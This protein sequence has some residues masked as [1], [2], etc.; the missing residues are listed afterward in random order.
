[1][2]DPVAQFIGQAKAVRLSPA[3]RNQLLQGIQA[4]TETAAVRIGHD[5]R[6]QVRMEQPTVDTFVASAKSVELSAQ[7]RMSLR[8]ALIERM[9]RPRVHAW[10]SW[11]NVAKGMPAFAA[12]L[13]LIGTGASAS[14][15]AENSVPGDLLYPVK[16]HVNEV[17]LQRFAVSA[18]D[19]AR[20]QAKRAIRRLREAEALA[21]QHRLSEESTAQLQESFGMHAR[22]V[23]RSIALMAAS[24]D[25]TAASTVG[26]EF[27]ASLE[28][29]AVIM[30]RLA[31]QR[32]STDEHLEQLASQVRT[33]QRD[34]ER[35]RVKVEIALSA[36]PS[37]ERQA[38]ALETVD[39][40][41][42]WVEQSRQAVPAPEDVA[43]EQLALADTLLVQAKEKI[44]AGS[45]AD[46]FGLVR[47]GIRNAEEARLISELQLASPTTI[48]VAL[49][50][51]ADTAVFAPATDAKR[52]AKQSDTPAEEALSPESEQ[53]T[54]ARALPDTNA[55]RQRLLAVRQE[56][57]ASRDL[58]AQEAVHEADVKL[59]NAEATLTM[60]DDFV[61]QQNL[62]QAK[63]YAA[64]VVATLEYVEQFAVKK[65]GGG[66]PSA[67]TMA[68]AP[69]VPMD[70][71]PQAEQGDTGVPQA[72]Q[73]PIMSPSY[74]PARKLIEE[75]EK[76]LKQSEAVLDAETLRSAGE[77]LLK[78]RNALVDAQTAFDVGDDAKAQEL[79]TRVEELTKKTNKTLAEGAKKAI[80]EHEAA[81]TSS[82]SAATPPP[83]PDGE[84]PA[85][86][87]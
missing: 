16:I 18:E 44:D 34:T 12:F 80:L 65:R 32:P 8:I 25:A 52:M 45:Y 77:I 36:L 48:A 1:M 58:L 86:T 83:A 21:A 56:V 49:V 38:T 84:F 23:R 6:L 2:T 66:A 22:S 68:M 72:L 11:L 47:D 43:H 85:G 17:V 20:L 60:A 73:R 24:Q 28:A 5:E 14:L 57:A 59:T 50:P 70:A 63:E 4:S 55:L 82:S 42:A 40:A 79:F 78:A 35:S 53:E 39:A 13:L 26:N 41:K 15:A 10:L 69:A 67:A 71:M 33:A 7:E 46:G 74:E 75:S 3:E 62:D 31:T 81:T 27:Q 30:E 64:N 54:S 19:Q 51:N 9:Q 87:R 29:H 37:D 61:A 76:L